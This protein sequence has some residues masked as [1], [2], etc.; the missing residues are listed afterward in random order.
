MPSTL[1]NVMDR[2]KRALNPQPGAAGDGDHM[3]S[4]SLATTL[5]GEDTTVGVIKTEERFGYTYLPLQTGAAT[6]NLIKSGAGFLHAITLNNP[7]AA[8]QMLL[9]DSTASSG[10]AIFSA[11]FNA[12]AGPSYTLFYDVT[13]A[14][15][16]VVTTLSLG[17]SANYTVAWR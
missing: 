15:G 4:V 7:A 11:V 8:Q 10:T 12:S 6:A 5:A 13:F 16:L 9:M 14:T 1:D 17:A 2:L 3:L